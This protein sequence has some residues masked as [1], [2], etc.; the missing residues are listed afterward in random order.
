MMMS[1]TRD[2]DRK[3]HPLGGKER[4]NRRKTFIK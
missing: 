2:F 1:V 3:D 4:K